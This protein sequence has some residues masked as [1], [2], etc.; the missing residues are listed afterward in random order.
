MKAWAF[1]NYWG[2]VSGLPLKSLLPWAFEWC[3]RS[4]EIMQAVTRAGMQKVRLAGRK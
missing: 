1:L 2:L 3:F 4:L